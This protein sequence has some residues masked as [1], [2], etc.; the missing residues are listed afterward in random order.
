MFNLEEVKKMSEHDIR[1]IICRD[2]S[3]NY[4][5]KIRQ[6]IMQKLT[7]EKIPVAKCGVNT[8]IDKIL[9]LKKES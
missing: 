8:I 6:E 5:K 1:F 4:N 7:G 3:G 9:E 2:Y